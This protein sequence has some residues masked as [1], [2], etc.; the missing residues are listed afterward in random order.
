MLNGIIHA[1][2]YLLSA[3]LMGILIDF[4]VINL[5]VDCNDWADPACV[6]PVKYLEFFLQ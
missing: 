6:T 4:V 1:L 5:L 2:G 3:V